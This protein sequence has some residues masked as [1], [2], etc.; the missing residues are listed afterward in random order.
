ML[1]ACVD[2]L[3]KENVIAFIASSPIYP[4]REIKKAE[5][6]ASLL[7]AEHIVVKTSEHEGERFIENSVERCYACKSQLLEM[8][9][10]LVAERGFLHIVEGSNLDDLQDFRP[11][12]KAIEEKGVKTPLIIS[13]LRKADIREISEFLWLPTSKKPSSACLASRIPYGTRIERKILKMIEKAEGFLRELGLSQLRVRYHGEVARIEVLE[14][15]VDLL[16]KH[17]K[18]VV[19]RLRTVGFLYVT[20]DLAGYRS[21]SLNEAIFRAS[22][23]ASRRREK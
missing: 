8:A 10:K 2:I 17:R 15:Q 1:K 7:G 21:G 13:C 22:S 12:I 5:R 4:E 6:I 11:G 16:L 19:E 14:D 20:F 3:S 9:E 23:L 18:I